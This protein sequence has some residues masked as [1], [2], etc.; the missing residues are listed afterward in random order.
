MSMAR[1]MKRELIEIGSKS[2]SVLMAKN[3]SKHKSL[4]IKRFKILPFRSFSL[5]E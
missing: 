1:A 5:A 2:P 4:V 3:K